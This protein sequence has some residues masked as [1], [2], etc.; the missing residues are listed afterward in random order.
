MAVISSA[1]VCMA[2]DSPDLKA[3]SKLFPG[4][5]FEDQARSSDQQPDNSV[6][7]EAYYIG[8]GDVFQISVV[9]S[10]SIQYTGTVNENCDVYIPEL[11]IIKI[12]KTNLVQAKKRIA[13]F[14]AS[15]LKRQFEVYVS[16]VK[17]KS[18]MVSVS[19]AVSSPGTC[20]L[21][22]TSRLFDAI[23]AANGGMVPSYN[24]YDYRAVEC[25]NRDSVHVFDLFKYLLANNQSENPYLY[26]GDNIRLSLAQ[27]RV[28]IT[29]ALKSQVTGW[30][31][32][33]QD[34]Q[35]ADFL[36]LFAFDASADSDHIIIQRT[37][38]D[39]SSLTKI[40]SLREPVSFTL[41]DRDLIIVSEKEN[42]PQALAVS[43]RGEIARPG[44]YP[45]VKNVTKA[46]DLVAEAGGATRFG[47][48]ERAYVVRRKKMLSEEMKQNYN[49]LKPVV[50]TGLFD[51]SVRPEINSGLFR[52]NASNDFS[53]LRLSDN[54][55]GLVLESE[56]EIVIPKK[57][58]CVYVSGSVCNPGAYPFVA[59]GT[60]SHY[61]G[62]AG[63]Y[64]SK[65]DRSNSFVVTYYG[66]VMQVKENGAIEEGDVIVVPDSQQYKFLTLVF[67]PIL[68]AI[69]VTI[70]TILAIYTNVHH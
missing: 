3:Y 60:K 6:V 42:Y 20:K 14:V 28:L 29:G 18:A 16:L 17:T 24:D 49:A 19:G 65:A 48:S 41:K 63:G 7:P 43:I 69:A 56:D 70:S 1:V 68:S 22:G 25:R 50:T 5:P 39:N 44:M 15:K 57:E 31:P 58:F 35:A 47:N 21:P 66:S 38:P 46:A 36:S 13:D 62:L 2:L 34:E 33:R 8:G 12:G 37:N 40:F 53:V 51:N 26:P 4:A 32:I 10:P 64:S 27:R 55:D 61:I 11:G 30:I 52:M 9:E 54:K 59:G 67:I 45:L 23:K